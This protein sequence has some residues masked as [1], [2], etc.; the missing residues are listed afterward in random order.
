MGCERAWWVL[1]GLLRQGW[2]S[3]KAMLGSPTVGSMPR[4]RRWPASGHWQQ[5]GSRL[6]SSC[7]QSTEASPSFSRL[8]GSCPAFLHV[9]GDQR[10]APVELSARKARRRRPSSRPSA[11]GQRPAC[12]RTKVRSQGCALLGA[13][14]FTALGLPG[15]PQRPWQG[16]GAVHQA[17]GSPWSCAGAAQQSLVAPLD[18]QL[19][20]MGALGACRPPSSKGTQCVDL[21]MAALSAGPPSASSAA[22]P[23]PPL[24]ARPHPARCRRQGRQEP[25]QGKERQR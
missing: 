6:E 4:L 2:G 8:P 16:S 13:A 22:H 19:L 21:G 14:A 20:A 1:Q 9:Q 18:W 12:P 10:S 17:T 24:A 25:P 3:C 5:V 7:L 11:P 23:P 15:G